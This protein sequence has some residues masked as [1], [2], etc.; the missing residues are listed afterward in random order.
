MGYKDVIDE[1]EHRQEFK[2]ISNSNRSDKNHLETGVESRICTKPEAT[3]QHE[4]KALTKA[5]TESM[6]EMMNYIPEQHPQSKKLENYCKFSDEVRCWVTM[7]VCIGISVFL[8]K[9]LEEEIN[10]QHAEESKTP[11]VEYF[12]ILKWP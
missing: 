6:K 9:C 4:Y 10:L 11:D 7:L 8:L 2:I 12:D 1:D 3:W 5:E